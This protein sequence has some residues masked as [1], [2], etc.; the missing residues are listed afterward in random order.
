[1]SDYIRRDDVVDL[2]RMAYH[3]E[4]DTAAGALNMAMGLVLDQ[5]TDPVAAA[6]V[7]FMEAFQE[8]G[9]SSEMHDPGDCGGEH[10]CDR[11]WAAWDAYRAAVA[12]REAARE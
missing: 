8:S 9:F 2:L 7:A 6:A 10:G 1:M 3:E 11:L 5:A 12:E 4:W